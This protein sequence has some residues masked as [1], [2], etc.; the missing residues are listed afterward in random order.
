MAE[1]DDEKLDRVRLMSKDNGET[2]DLSPNDRAALKYVLSR[3]DSAEET[4]Q[5]AFGQ[6]DND[7]A[8][9]AAAVLNSYLSTWVNPIHD[10]EREKP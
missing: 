1:S 2:W 8:G 4:I 7:E 5:D 3:L 10:T 6:A 9:D